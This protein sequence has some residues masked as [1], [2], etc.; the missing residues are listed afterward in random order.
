LLQQS[1]PKLPLTVVDVDSK[2]Q[3]AVPATEPGLPKPVAKV[4]SSCMLDV[5]IMHQ[6]LQRLLHEAF[7][8]TPVLAAGFNVNVPVPT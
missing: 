6:E 4:I 7:R 1:S 8:L 2:S 3:F 5:S